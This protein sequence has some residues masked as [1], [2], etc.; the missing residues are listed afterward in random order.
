MADCFGTLVFTKSTD[1]VFDADKLLTVANSYEW[2]RE[3][4]RWK[5]KNDDGDRYLSVGGD[6]NYPSGIPLVGKVYY[7]DCPVRG[8]IEL[9][10]SELKAEDSVYGVDTDEAPL[11][12]LSKEVSSC[13][14]QGWVEFSAVGNEAR[15]FIYF[16][17]VRVYADGKVVLS[18][19]FGGPVV[20]RDG[21]DEVYVPTTLLDKE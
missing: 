18:Q 11:E 9:S 14:S 4:T 19:R 8:D 6:L 16:E 13:L 20:D 21:R 1:C 17:S 2:D 7:V 12:Q 3:L 10:R 15:R 5:L